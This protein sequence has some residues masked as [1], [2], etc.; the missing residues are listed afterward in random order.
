MTK[1]NKV[2]DE[3]ITQ[4]FDKGTFEECINKTVKFILA[5]D[6]K[7]VEPLVKIPSQDKLPMY[8]WISF[9]KD[10]IDQ[11][12]TN[13]GGGGL[14]EHK[15]QRKITLNRERLIDTCSQYFVDLGHAAIKAKLKN[16][17]MVISPARG[18]ADA[19]I[20]SL[21]DLVEVVP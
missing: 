4:C 17:K 8:E 3:L 20:S 7:I 18:L 10:G 6:K 12:L 16:S 11:T 9:A 1:A 19:I 21:P 5:R 15:S 13:A 2:R 14:D